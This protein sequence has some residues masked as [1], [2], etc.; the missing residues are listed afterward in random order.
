[1][2]TEHEFRSKAV[3]NES[4]YRLILQLKPRPT[5]WAVTILFYVAV[6]LGRAL[7]ERKGLGPIASHRR[8]QNL[9]IG[10]LAAPTAPYSAY[11]SLQDESEAARYRCKA[12]Q[13]TDLRQLETH[14]NTFRKWVESEMA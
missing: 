14:L 1:M 6:Q 13:D 4:L 11:R 9:L 7:V 8:F 2:P 5:D 12:F 3:E 10:S